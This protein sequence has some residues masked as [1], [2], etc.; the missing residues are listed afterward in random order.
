MISGNFEFLYHDDLFNI[1]IN[2]TPTKTKMDY[3]WLG[4]YISGINEQIIFN[5]NYAI[6]PGIL[7]PSQNLPK[8]LIECL[9]ICS[10]SWGQLSDIDDIS[11]L[12]ITSHQLQNWLN[13]QKFSN[14][15]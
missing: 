7:T 13:H 4:Q 6:M 12:Y 14:L 8:D 3:L 2:N 15:Y 10:S 1:R 5:F 11:L 9:E